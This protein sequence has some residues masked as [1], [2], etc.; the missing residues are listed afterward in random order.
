MKTIESQKQEVLIVGAGPVGLVLG[1][2]LT[3]NHVPIR[4]IDKRETWSGASKALSITPRTLE[5][6][7]FVGVSDEMVSK[8][9]TSEFIRFFNFKGKQISEINF[10]DLS[11]PY[12]FILQLPQNRTIEILTDA[13]KRQG[14]IVDRPY[15][16]DKIHKNNT[17]YSCILKDSLNSTHTIIE[18]DYVIGCDGASSRVRNIMGQNF[19]GEK[20][21]DAFIMAD[22]RLS[23]HP[24]DN[25]RYMYYLKR[26]SSL[27]IMPL[28]I[29]HYRIISTASASPDQMTDND[30]LEELKDA[31]CQIGMPNVEVSHPIWVST[32]NPKQYIVD[33]YQI[34]HLILAGDAAHI[35]SPVGSQGLNTGVQDAINLGWKLAKVLNGE[36]DKGLLNSYHKERK[37]IALRLF[38]YNEKLSSSV[39]G[40]NPIKRDLAIFKRRLLNINKFHEKEKL[41]VSQLNLKYFESLLFSEEILKRSFSLKEN[42]QLK[43][44]KGMRFPSIMVKHNDKLINIY[45]LFSI[46]DYLLLTFSANNDDNCRTIIIVERFNVTIMKPE[47]I[48]GIYKTNWKPMDRGQKTHLVSCLV[49]P[50]SYIESVNICKSTTAKSLEYSCN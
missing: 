25:N 33:H 17:G 9:I 31:F 11:S 30:V 4:I 43:L 3:A 15:E 19:L 50:D 16:L 22:V 5:L 42:K 23:N 41:Q 38:N 26:R 18:A 46:T 37:P 49:R 27:Y 28:D 20:S 13:L 47:E 48:K 10:R 29:E 1:L 40:N 2:V 39:F 34:D 32:F 44:K 36:G 45:T 7:S 12:P 21:K 35:Q 14:V 8:G 6:L 24:F